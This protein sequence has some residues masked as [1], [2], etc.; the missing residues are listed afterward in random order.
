MVRSIDAYQQ[1][2][3]MLMKPC[4][5]LIVARLLFALDEARKPIPFTVGLP[6]G[7]FEFEQALH[8]V[9][10]LRKSAEAALAVAIDDART[11]I[12]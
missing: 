11:L 4:E 2:K 7:K 1:P 9:G 12:A 8:A 3:D 6:P 10:E 5:K